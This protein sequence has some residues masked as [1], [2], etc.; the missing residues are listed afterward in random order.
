MNR[1]S[2]A[3]TRRRA[4]RPAAGSVIATA[5]AT[6]VRAAAEAAVAADVDAEAVDVTTDV[7]AVMAATVAMVVTAAEADTE[8]RL[9]SN[10]SRVTCWFCKSCFFERDGHQAVPLVSDVTDFHAQ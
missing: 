7:A 1:T 9:L 5:I 3:M 8:S 2:T 6:V 4:S 10:P